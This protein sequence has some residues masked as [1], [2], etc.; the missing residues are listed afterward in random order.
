M[1]A[2]LKASNELNFC[3][4]VRELENERVLLT[5]FIHTKHA[6]TVFN[7]YSEDHSLFAHMPLGPYDTAKQFVDDFILGRIQSD[8]GMVAYA[9]YDKT[10]PS[11][12]SPRS[13]AGMIGYLHSSASDLQT[14]IG[15]V[16]V[17]PRFQRTHVASNAIGLLM[18]YALDLP[19]AGGLGLRRCVWMANSVNTASIR[20]AERMGFVKEGVLRWDR[21]WATG[22][23]KVGNGRELRNGDPREGCLGRDSVVLSVCWD[24]WEGGVREKVQG[25]MNRT[26]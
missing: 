19:S 15:F 25:V 9:I 10:H 16:T 8:P 2:S 3:F 24:D 22:S 17:L 13:H 23:E 4:P 26:N 12:P 1:S 7:A 14:E 6:E 11:Y 18:F 5:P 20:A 21:V